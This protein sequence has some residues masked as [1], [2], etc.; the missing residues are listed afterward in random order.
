MRISIITSSYPR[1]P[2][3]GT[4]PFIKSIAEHLVAQGNDVEVVAPYDPEVK[5]IETHGVNVHRFRYTWPDRFHIV[6][7][8]RSLIADVRLR[9]LVIFLLPFF[10]AAAFI[11]LFRV[12]I[13]Q[14]SQLINAH[15][16]LPNGLVGAWVATFLRIPLVISVHGSD[17]YMAQ[18]N[19]LFRWVAGSIFRRADGVTACSPELYKAAIALGARKKTLLLPYGVDPALFHPMA[20]RLEIRRSYGWDQSELVIAALGRLVYKKGF[21]I[22]IDAIVE[23]VKRH[24]KVRLVLGGAGPLYGE[25]ARQAEQSG[26]ANAVHFMGRIT[27]DHVQ[28]FLASADIFVLPSLKDKYGNMDGLP[29]VLLEAMSCGIPVVASNI[30]GGNMLLGDG[31]GGLLVEPGDIQ[32]FADAIL[33]LADDPGKLQAL[34]HGARQVIEE[35]FSWDHI[36]SMLNDFFKKIVR[37]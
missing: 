22:A 33:A 31:R 27:W 2:G 26:V 28:D 9:P 24:Q 19:F 20:N 35:Q 6:G 17:I 32:G 15:W 30:G 18:S 8:A 1:F 10:L 25:L 36:V 29:N 13:R 23:I 3:D 14:K 12:A 7:H 16:V 21:D 4:A 37:V 11:K 5:P 34:G